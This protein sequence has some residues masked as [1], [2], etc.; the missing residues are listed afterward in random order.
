MVYDFKNALVDAPPA[1]D[2][3]SKLFQTVKLT[4]PSQSKGRH[5][6]DVDAAFGEEDEEK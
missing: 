2:D 1:D 6:F 4:G 5:K 3:E